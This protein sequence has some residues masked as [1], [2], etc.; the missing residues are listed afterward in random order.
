MDFGWVW[1][2]LEHTWRLPRGYQN[3]SK[4]EFEQKFYFL[5]V[6]ERF[7]WHFEGVLGVLWQGFGRLWLSFW[8]VWGHLGHLGPPEWRFQFLG[9]I[10]LG[11]VVLAGFGL[12]F[13]VFS[14]CFFTF[15]C[16]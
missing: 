14:N 2:G 6:L 5:T 16:I 10:L 13:G 3:W 8:S 12:H 11:F 4:S 1:G 7:G 9:C 15:C